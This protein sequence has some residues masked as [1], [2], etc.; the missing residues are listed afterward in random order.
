[1]SSSNDYERPRPKGRQ[2]SLSSGSDIDWSAGPSR[3]A[4]SR[5]LTPTDTPVNPF[6]PPGLIT[7]H[8]AQHR[9]ASSSSSCA[10]PA[11]GTTTRSTSSGD[12]ARPRRPTT[13]G[14]AYP[15]PESFTSPPM[16]PL[17]VYNSTSR[18]S[19]KILRERPKSTMLSDDAPPEKPWITHRDPYARIAYWVT[20]G[21]ILLGL[22][23]ESNLCVVLNENFDSPEAVFGANGTFFREVDMSGFGNGEFEMTTDST[24]NSYSFQWQIIHHPYFHTRT[25]TQG[26]SKASTFDSAAYYRACSAISNSTIGKVINPVQTARLTTRQSANIKYGR[27]D[28]VAKLPLGDWLWPAIWM[29]PTNNTYGPW[30]MSGNP[31]K[32]D[33]VESRGN[34][35]EYPY[36]GANYVRG[37]LNWGPT[38]W[39]NAG[40][41][42]FGWW[43]MKRGTFAD[44]FHTYTLEWDEKFIR[45][46]VDTRLHA[47]WTMKFTVPFWN[48]GNFPAVVQNGTELVILN[49]PWIN[50]TAATPF[51]QSF[52]LIL[53]LGVGG[54]NGWFPDSKE[55]PWLDGSTSDC[56][57]RFLGARKQW[58]PTWPNKTEDRSLVVDSVKMWQ[59]CH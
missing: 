37:T 44:T 49:N 8:S 17:T 38:S 13:S 54:T 20:Y 28:V 48:H 4:S 24:N 40:W 31:V 23:P 3:S 57:F 39:L 22:L 41:T 27:V 30:P 58:L 10:F 53:S 32:F 6:S 1:M 42:T 35:P 34:G 43:Y 25:L 16:R 46:Y 14:A 5:V 18:L 52:Y 15:R 51:D 2:G 11:S 55:K 59:K 9:P 7:F 36:Q 29:L 56:R 45:M 12:F 21:V 26:G 47:T 50:G 33:I 19:S